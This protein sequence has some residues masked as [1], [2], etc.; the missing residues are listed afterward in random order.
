MREANR[1]QV[2]N[3][4][5]YILMVGTPL[6]G[7]ALV[8][9]LGQ[10]I[11]P[12]SY[13]GGAWNIEIDATALR[14]SPCAELLTTLKQPALNI[15]QSGRYLLVRLN[16][17]AETSVEGQLRGTT[18][19]A[20]PAA[21]FEAGSICDGKNAINFTAELNKATPELNGELQV[22]GCAGCASI[23]FKAIR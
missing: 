4:C 11:Q 8:L 14:N 23:A 6:L 18:L 7:V 20:G 9:Y 13:I 3:V 21:G 12:E 16:N 10:R 1:K 15:S 5:T 2:R 19:R 22:A 17:R